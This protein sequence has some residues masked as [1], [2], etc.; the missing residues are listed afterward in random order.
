MRVTKDPAH[1]VGH[2]VCY[3]CKTEFDADISECG[4]SPE[5][6]GHFVAS[7]RCPTCGRRCTNDVERFTA[8]KDDNT[9]ELC[10]IA[11]DEFYHIICD[12][13]DKLLEN[14]R[15]YPDQETKCIMCCFMSLGSARSRCSSGYD[16]F[17]NS[18]IA[19]YL[20]VFGTGIHDT[21]KED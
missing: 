14:K 9:N 3:V 5:Y 15:L 20:M 18:C 12:M 13:N 16:G 4:I 11:Y 2:F 17:C 7:V 1:K 21:K 10:T 8:K 19:S 6:L